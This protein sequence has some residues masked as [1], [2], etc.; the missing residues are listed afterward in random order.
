MSTKGNRSQKPIKSDIEKEKVNAALLYLLQK[1]QLFFLVSTKKKKTQNTGTLVG[2][3]NVKYNDI[4]T[5]FFFITK[6]LYP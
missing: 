2:L 3:S 4:Q 5:F 6:K 1:Q